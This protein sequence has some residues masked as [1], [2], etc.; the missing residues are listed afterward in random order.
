MKN[1][2]LHTYL[3]A[4]SLAIVAL[5]YSPLVYA[6]Q[7]SQNYALTSDY[8]DCS[9]A[10]RFTIPLDIDVTEDYWLKAYVSDL[11]QGV[12]AYLYSDTDFSFEVY[13]DCHFMMSVYSTTFKMNRTS[14]VYLSNIQAKLAE[15]GITNYTS[16]FYIRISPIDGK[17]G[18]LVFRPDT[19]RMYSD[20]QDPLL[21]APGLNLRS[22]RTSDV[23]ALDPRDFSQDEDLFVRWYTK[24]SVPCQ[25]KMTLGACDG[26]VLEEKTLL[27]TKDV[28]RLT[29]E[30]LSQAAQNNQ[31]LYFHF[32]HAVDTTNYV[33]CLASRFVEKVYEKST[34]HG[35][36]IT[37]GDTTF[38]ESTYYFRDTAYMSTNTFYIRYYNIVF[39]EP[40]PVYDTLALKST[41]LPYTYRGQEI[42]A[43]GDYDFT[44]TKAKKCDERYILHA[45]HDIDTLVHVADTFLCYGASYNY[46]GKV[47]MQD[48]SFAQETWHND[49]TLLIDSLYLHFA[50]TPELVYD[51]IQLEE[52]KYNRTFN[53]PGD[54]HFTFTTECT[55]SILLHVLAPEI[56]Y[57][58]IYIDTTL[59]H[60]GVY[61][62]WGVVY[63]ADTII[64]D[65]LQNSTYHYTIEITSLNFIVPEYQYDTLILTR[66]ELPYQ[67][68]DTTISIDTTI[69][70]FDDYELAYYSQEGCLELMIYLSVQEKSTPTSLDNNLLFDRPRLIL[71]DGVVYILR[72]SETFTLLG[73]QL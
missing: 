51:T 50:T 32:E 14:T 49:D 41:Q 25:A 17:G 34:C 18:R 9:K 64:Y 10:A 45:Y 16:P 26:E 8:S 55:D 2:S 58:S 11:D 3:A 39:T 54:Y 29:P 27:L 56:V 70:D 13:I 68:L 48:T 1:H 42:L 43:Y 20:C 28:F 7:T 53:E 72:G 23:Y 66:N 5:F 57:D 52:H 62:H 71:R 46:Q 12:S 63:N 21:L 38:Y 40:D 59:C 4:L 19:E 33:Q 30:L 65:T 31:L 24:D 15:F 22:F 36:S 47:Y 69:L 44:I 35:K 6:E 60:G 67:Y 73:E 37:I 61:N